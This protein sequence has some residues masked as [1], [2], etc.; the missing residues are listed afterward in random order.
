MVNLLRTLRSR[1]RPTTTPAASASA[2]TTR[3]TAARW[4]KNLPKAEQFST[5]EALRAPNKATA[6]ARSV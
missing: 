3:S 5:G 4:V 1:R 6:S 2:A